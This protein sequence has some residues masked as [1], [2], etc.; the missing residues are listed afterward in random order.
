VVSTTHG[1]VLLGPTALDIADP[2]DR[3]TDPETVTWILDNARRL[4][5]ATADA[6]VMKTFA[7]NRPAGDEPHRLRTDARQP[8]LLHVTDRSAGVSISPAAAELALTRPR[9]PT[10]YESGPARPTAAARA[11]CA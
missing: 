11:R 9:Q 5:P 10:A 7:A 2:G 1:S 3:A 6:Y 8:C 4:V